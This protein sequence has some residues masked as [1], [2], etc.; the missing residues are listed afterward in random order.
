VTVQQLRYHPAQAAFYASRAR[1][2][3]CPAGRRSGKTAWGK[4]RLVRKALTYT[5]HPDGRFLVC[6]P[7]RP[8]VKR[9]YWHDL[10][11]LIPKKLVR[12]VRSSELTLTLAPNGA[13]IE[14]LGMERPERAEGA[15]IDHA[16][17][18]EYGNMKPTVWSEH[19]RPALST[20]GR[21]GTA[22]FIGVP[23]GMNHYLDLWKRALD[24]DNPDWAGFHWMSADILDA[25]EIAQARRELDELSFRQEYE[26][27][28]VTY[29]GQAYYPFSREIHASERLPY[30]V[31]LPL[32]LCFDFNV[33]PGTAVVCQELEYAG[34]NPHVADEYTAV[35][36]EVFIPRNST[37]HRVC[38]KLVHDWGRHAGPV[39]L[40]GDATGGNPDTRSGGSDW[41]II[42][43]YLRQYFGQRLVDRHPH[44]NP[45]QRARV[46]AVNSRLRSLSGE[47]RLLVDPVMAP[48]VAEDFERVAW[49]EGGAGEL[50]KTDRRWTHFTDGVGY[51]VA[52]Q[53]P[54]TGP[55]VL[56]KE[57]V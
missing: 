21:L 30:D 53:F 29:Q 14:L 2:N 11:Q 20:P 8:Q 25:E 9:I 57:V 27:S 7:T 31:N 43:Q 16:L 49:F 42:N 44:A 38:E 13:V 15:P 22:D 17:L 18:D 10:Q 24:P 32:V 37:T 35:L 5:A 4:R 33:S 12:R 26:G 39:F 3:V 47:V 48:H 19:V 1:F 40:E 55:R 52:R 36:G 23:E 54:I 51:Y 28:F 45:T 34:S 6:A 46:N 41:I 56:V 50:D